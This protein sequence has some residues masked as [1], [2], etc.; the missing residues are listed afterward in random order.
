M[1]FLFPEITDGIGYV[2]PCRLT[3]TEVMNIRVDRMRAKSA[4]LTTA[5]NSIQLLECER[6]QISLRQMVGATRKQHVVAARYRA[7]RRC[8]DELGMS[9]FEI[10]RAF[11]RDHSTVSH[12]LKKRRQ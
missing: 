2:D 3:P 6:A 7:M 12:A 8:R 10:G 9:V 5:V 11:D 1:T 4:I